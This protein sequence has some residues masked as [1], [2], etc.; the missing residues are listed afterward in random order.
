MH[1][2][3]D[4]LAAEALVQRATVRRDPVVLRRL[5]PSDVVDIAVDGVRIEAVRVYQ[6]IALKLRH[7]NSAGRV[8]HRLL[9]AQAQPVGVLVD[10]S[11]HGLDGSLQLGVSLALRTHVL[12]VHGAEERNHLVRE[13]VDALGVK[14]RQRV[15]VC[16][17]VREPDDDQLRQP[18]GIVSGTT[19][20]GE[21]VEADQEQPGGG[22][23]GT[24]W[25]TGGL[26]GV[27]VGLYIVVSPLRVHQHDLVR[28]VHLGAEPHRRV[29]A[30]V[31][32]TA[33]RRLDVAVTLRDEVLRQTVDDVSVPLVAADVQ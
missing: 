19:A 30:D 8:Q 10:M 23:V 25:T 14:H 13:R 33:M 27:K 4:L 11:D 29:A 6:S 12:V 16:V 15:S 1:A 20:L 32:Y 22:A 9:A 2:N 7:L 17:G 18:A 24:V 3:V 26:R 5:W 21:Q 28:F 31:R